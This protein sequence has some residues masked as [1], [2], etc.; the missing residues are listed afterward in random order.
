MYII[1][2][3][4]N[5]IQKNVKIALLNFIIKF[6]IKNYLNIKSKVKNNLIIQDL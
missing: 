4:K 5:I 3:I 6:V 1:T 2:I